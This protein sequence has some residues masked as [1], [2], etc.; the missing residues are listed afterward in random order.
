MEHQGGNLKRRVVHLIRDRLQPSEIY[1]LI[2]SREAAYT[3][4]DQEAN[5]CRDRAFMA[6][7]YASSGRITEVTGGPVFYWDKQQKKSFKVP[8]KKH[9]GLW[10]ENLHVSTERIL[11]SNMETV[12]RSQ[13]IIDRYGLQVTIRDPFAIPLIRGLYDNPFWDQLVPF[14]WLIYEY[15]VRY[16]PKSGKLFPFEDTRAYQIVREVTGN[17]PNWFRSQA[18]HFYGH[19]LLTDSVKLSKFLNVLDPKQVKH[20]IGYDWTAQ[21]KDKSVSMNFDWIDPSIQQIKDRLGILVVK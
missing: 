11:V 10:V 2:T 16:A 17:Y 1:R 6:V 20:Y 12:K 21:L 18:E 5:A 19:F 9:P 7:D 15:L 13:K 8:D 3:P 4:A 14:G